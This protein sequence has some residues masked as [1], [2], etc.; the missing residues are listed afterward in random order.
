MVLGSTK[1]HYKQ[2][3]ELVEQIEKSG[4]K[5]LGIVRNHRRKSDKKYYYRRKYYHAYGKTE[6]TKSD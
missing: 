3:Q 1:V 5:M 2:A 4:S 6:Y